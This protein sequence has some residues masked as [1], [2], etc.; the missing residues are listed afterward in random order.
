MLGDAFRHSVFAT[1]FAVTEVEN[2]ALR[3]A[4]AA[5]AAERSA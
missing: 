5:A 3:P 1:G 4:P 2:P